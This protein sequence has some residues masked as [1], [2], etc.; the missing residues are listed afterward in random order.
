MNSLSKEKFKKVGLNFK[1][2]SPK[3]FNVHMEYVA[4]SR[5]IKQTSVKHNS[6]LTG[7]ECRSL[8]LYTVNSARDVM[9]S[10]A[11]YFPNFSVQNWSTV[12]GSFLKRN[13]MPVYLPEYSRIV[14]IRLSRSSHWNMCKRAKPL[15]DITKPLG[16]SETLK[17]LYKEF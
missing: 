5:S 12:T 11:L 9:H 13:E 6:L 7:S 1:T 2:T 16:R 10:S 15:L 14:L 4:G 8:T 3:G 17:K